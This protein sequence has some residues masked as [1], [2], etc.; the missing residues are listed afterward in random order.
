[1][2]V[3]A[4][5]AELAAELESAPDTRRGVVMTMG[6]LH[7]GHLSLVRRAREVADQVVVTI[8][9]NPL[10]FGPT[11]DLE[12]YPRDL[13]GDVAKLA[14]AGADVV[15][16]PSVEQ[17]YPRPTIVQVDA[18]RLGEVL[19]GQQR[20][21]L[22]DGA[23]T[24]ILKLLNLT[25][26][27][28]AL[29]GQKDAQQ[30]VAVRRMVEDLD[31]PV[32]VLGVETVRE[33]DGLAMSSRNAYLDPVQRAH[34]RGLFRALA[35]GR[36]AA[37]DGAAPGQVRDVALEALADTAIDVDYV[38]ITDDDLE[39]LAQDYH[40]PALLLVAGRVGGTRLIDN[41][42]VRIGPVAGPR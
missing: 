42:R 11:E 22:I 21:R 35:A 3:V 18:G 13:D 8:F 20:P 38:A 32:E 16:V 5:R 14:S 7:E 25:R 26:P 2:K 28:V 15:F 4:T 31:L 24:V 10:Q 40:G 19:E 36:D 12:R 9:V 39:P 27:D 1:M 33:P 23:L 30:L 41:T 17:V 29:F 37:A 6:A 34:A